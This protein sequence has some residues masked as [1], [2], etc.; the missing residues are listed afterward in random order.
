VKI[1]GLDVSV[2]R[3]EVTKVKRTR[4]VAILTAAGLAVAGGGIALA[5]WT[6]GGSGTGAAASGAAANVTF[7]GGTVT[8]NLLFPGGTGD[9]VINVDNSNPFPVSV[10]SL[11]LPAG[12]ATAYS[13]SGQTT[14]NA[15]C[16]TGGTGVSWSYATKSL[17]GVIVAAKSGST[18]GSLTLT[19]TGGASMDNTSDNS[20][21]SS[22]FALPNVTSAVVSSSSGTP[23]A[24]I[25]Q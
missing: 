21:Q 23:V 20:C 8:G 9:V 10:D 16:N 13:D 15:A 19:L 7:T 4:R 14:L 5:F 12:A 11:V 24:T 18:D 2:D 3:S 17:T 25:S 1:L 6:A 22:F